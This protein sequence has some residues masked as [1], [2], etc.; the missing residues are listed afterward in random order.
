MGGCAGLHE[1]T[2]EYQKGCDNGAA[3]DLSGVPIHHDHKTVRSLLEG[4][5]AADRGEAEASEELPYEHVHLE[6]E[7]HVQAVKLAPMH[8]GLGEAQGAD[9]VLAACQRWL[10]AHRDTLF[11]KRDALLK[12]YLGDYVETEEEHTLFCVC[13]SLVLNKGLVCQHNAKGRG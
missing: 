12:K 11:Q 3:D 9:A 13:N 6:H 8:S 1:L 4:A 7:A 5:S 2:L 10:H